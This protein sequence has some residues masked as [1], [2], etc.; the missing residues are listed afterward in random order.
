M[1]QY[2]CATGAAKSAISMM[3]MYNMYMILLSL[4]ALLTVVQGIFSVLEMCV[5]HYCNLI[6]Y[7]YTYIDIIFSRTILTMNWNKE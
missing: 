6:L 7:R 1:P 3:Y 4:L 5:L 2:A